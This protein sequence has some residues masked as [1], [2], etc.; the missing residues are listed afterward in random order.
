MWLSYLAI[1]SP[2]YF[3]GFSI[4]KNFRLV[5]VV[6]MMDFVLNLVKSIYLP[7][8]WLF[9]SANFKPLYFPGINKLLIFHLVVVV[10]R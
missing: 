7:L 3:L 2:L 1:F 6:V 8:M 10:V 5:L 4:K 9:H